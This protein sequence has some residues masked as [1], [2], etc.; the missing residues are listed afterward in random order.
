M[1]AVIMAGGGG[2]RLHPLSRPERPKPFLPL[3]G[4]VSLL[5][6]TAARLPTDDITVVT[7][8]RYERLV[9]DQLPG[10]RV[11]AEP[12][13]RNTA[14]AIALATA[15]LERADDDVM[16]VVPADAYIDP[17]REGAYRDVLRTAADGLA[18][19]S[20][21]IADPLVTLGTRVTRPAIEYGYLVPRLDAREMVE[22][23]AAYP[24]AAFE[25]KPKPDRAAELFEQ[26]GVAWNAGIFLWRRRAIRAA[27]DRYTGLMRLIEPTVSSPVL[28]DHA[29]EQLKPI[30]IDHAVMEGAARNGEV[31]M[32]SMDVGW[33]DLGSWSALLAAIGA[34]GEGAVVQPGETVTVDDGDLVVRRVEGRL[35]VITPPERGRMTAAQQ[36]AVLRG[37][38]PDIARIR[39][40]IERCA[41]SGGPT[42]P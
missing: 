26:D 6:A 15:A 35:G 19:G 25:E 42:G 21:G 2:T 28:L 39:E 14:A 27:L 10:V 16:L 1:Y 38:A 33:S 37:A 30:S 20:F 12:R 24:L 40:L 36:I 34:R 3:L 11:L 17:A 23:L 5:Q 13:G 22:G 31:V 7:D 29:Y 41:E 8:G 4:R 32:G 9:R 18:T